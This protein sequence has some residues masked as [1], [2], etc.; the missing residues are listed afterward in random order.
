MPTG[1]TEPYNRLEAALL[2]YELAREQ[3]KPLARAEFLARYADLAGELGPLFD[4]VPQ[5][6][7]LACPL[8]ESLGGK[9]PLALPS[10]EG[11]EII[12]EIGRG[13]MGVVYKAKQTGT[14]QLVALKLLR[15]DWLAG[16][17]EPTRREAIEQFRNEARAAA[18]LQHPNRVRILHLEEHEGRPFYAMELIQGCSLADKLKRP[19]GVSKDAVGRYLASIAEAVQDAH[20]RGILHRDIKPGNILIEEETDEAKLTDFGL[21]MIAPTGVGPA[22]QSVREQRRVAGTLPYMSPEQTQDADAVTVRSDVYSLG[23]TLYEALTGVPPFTETS[24]AKLL[25]RIRDCEPEP[26]HKHNRDINQELERICLRCLC[27]VPEQRFTAREL[28][29]E[30]RE[31]EVR[32]HYIRIFTTLGTWMLA[33]APLHLAIDLVIYWMLQGSFWE[34]VVWLLMFSHALG[35]IPALL[36]SFRFTGGQGQH[37]RA[38]WGGR[39]LAFVFIAVAL[40]TGLAVPPRDIIL[41]MYSVGAALNGMA[42]L[43]EAS[44]MSW[45]LSWGPVGFWLVGVV[46]LFH[47]EAAPIY[48]GVYGALGA[49]FYGLYLR[50]LGKQLR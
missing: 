18:R 28:A 15:P 12:E 43:I 20:E 35:L 44:R 10:L 23:A 27:K 36:L 2:E 11:Y 1:E 50:K 22:E 26:P 21:A 5:I 6:E 4:A 34:P 14:E 49:V 32:L 41:L 24:R 42:Y 30:L 48:L 25:A 47:R 16:L 7:R 13:G 17:D 46:M 8:R 33:L 40:R 39:T 9:P 37:W 29:K 31:W 3:G 38:V 19:G 45:K